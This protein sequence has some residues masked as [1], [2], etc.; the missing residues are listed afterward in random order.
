VAACRRDGKQQLIRL[1]PCVQEQGAL[2]E[3]I[4]WRMSAHLSQGTLDP[5]SVSI[6]AAAALKEIYG[7]E[8]PLVEQ[9]P[10]DR[11]TLRAA[12]LADSAAQPS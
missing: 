8:W 4:V 1:T 2:G 3:P 6:G 5:R 11:Q 7:G 12:Q 9:Q 10:F